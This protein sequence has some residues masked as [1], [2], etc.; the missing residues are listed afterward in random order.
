M[1]RD[2]TRR[3]ARA[4]DKRVRTF[5][6]AGLSLGAVTVGAV[7]TMGFGSDRSADAL[8]A[9]ETNVAA[10]FS[11]V[12]HMPPEDVAQ[13]L[14][15]SDAAAHQ[16]VLVDVREASEYAVSRIANALRVEPDA[17]VEQ[18]LA[19][20]GDVRGKSVILYCSVGVRS[21][22]LA[23][24]VQAQLSNA[25]ARGVY[26]LSGGIFRWHNEQRRL[27]NAEGA[28]D[29]VHP[30]NTW[31]SQYVSRQDAVRYSPKP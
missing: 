22:K 7:G 10:E 3:A 20:L 26:N 8:R 16:I 12:T 31:W 11:D 4:F 18:V 29:F 2:L 25:G 17:D 24:R 21:S 6:V 14:Y 27:T 19:M 13:K 23:Q 15:R 30:Y 1:I 5:A 28:T 9:F